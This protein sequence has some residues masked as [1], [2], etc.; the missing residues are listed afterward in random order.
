M[1]KFNELADLAVVHDAPPAFIVDEHGL[2][3]AVFRLRLLRRARFLALGD[4]DGA[5]RLGVAPASGV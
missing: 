4:M 1:L 5:I 2:F 3:L